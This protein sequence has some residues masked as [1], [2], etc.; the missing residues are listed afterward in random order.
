MPY[1][2]VY[3]AKAVLLT[4]LDYGGPRVKQYATK[5]NESSIEDMLDQ[6]GKARDVTLL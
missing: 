4:D 1:F 2:M 3:G 5:Q 6:L